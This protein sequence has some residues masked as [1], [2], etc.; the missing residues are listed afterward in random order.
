MPSVVVVCLYR[1]NV[2]SKASAVYVQLAV[3]TFNRIILAA[4]IDSA[5]SAWPSRPRV[6]LYISC[7]KDQASRISRT[8]LTPSQKP[9]LVVGLA[10]C[11]ICVVWNWRYP[12]G[13][14]YR[15]R[16]YTLHTWLTGSSIQVVIVVPFIVRAFRKPI[17]N[18]RYEI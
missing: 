2:P 14:R 5:V 3:D 15:P 16:T 10:F 4:D 13:Y 8:S 11:R 6:L 18:F 9:G 7:Q 1:L 12:F 17:V